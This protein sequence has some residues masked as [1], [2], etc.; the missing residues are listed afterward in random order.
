MSPRLTDLFLNSQSDERLV[1]LVRAEHER[2][3]ATIVVRHRR[4]LHGLARRLVSD[5]TAED[6]VQQTFL[7]A[8][9]ALQSGA[10]VQH[11]SAWLH[12]ILRNTAIRSGS[13]APA[14]AALD[15]A[16]LFGEPLEES[17]QRRQQAFALF[18]ELAA[19]PT[20]QRDA[21]V[22]TALHGRSRE[23]I[24]ASTGV[25]EGAVRQLVP[26]ARA[27]LRTAVTALTPLPLA[28]WFASAPDALPSDQ[29]G[30]AAV[31]AGGMSLAAP[32]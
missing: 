28:S 3:F 24:A 15:A 14:A 32:G 6:V 26:R 31:G 21:L 16:A 30:E 27:T 10:E 22:A 18:A 11:L 7:S 2:A 25:S 29:L 12:R 19:L 13:G 1:G 4:S 17:V 23:A 8:Y 5:G 20:R 9:E